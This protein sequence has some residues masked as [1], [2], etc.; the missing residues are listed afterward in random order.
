MKNGKKTAFLLAVWLTWSGIAAGAAGA[1]NEKDTTADRI[2]AVENHLRPGAY[3]KGKE[4]PEWNIYDRMKRLHVPGVSIAVIDQGKIEWAK[5]YGV[6]EVGSN[7]PVTP[8]TLFQAAS[9]SKPVTAF[10]L[11][12]Q[13][14]GGGLSLDAPVNDVLKTWKVPDNEFTAKQNVTLRHLLTHSAGMTVDGFPG[15]A[16]GE[17]V[18]TLLQVLAGEKPANTPP[19]RVDTIPGSVWRYSGG[20]FLV[21]QLML[22]DLTG[23][24]FPD[25]MQAEILDPLGMKHSTF[26]Q[27]LPRE[28]MRGA[29][30]AHDMNG[31][32]IGGKW[33]VYPELAAAGLWTTPS[34]LCRFAIAL[35]RAATG[36]DQSILST[37]L[38][39]QML[40]PGVGGWGLGI[41]V[42]EKTGPD[43]ADRFF[44]HGGG[45]KGYICMLFAYISR[46]QGA[47]I[48]T[49]S[50]GGNQLVSEI[51][52]SLAYVYK[53]E[54]M[55][56]QA[57]EVVKVPLAPYCGEYQG[58]DASQPAYRVTIKGK[59][60]HLT[61]P[62]IGDWPL[63][64][65]SDTKF[66]YIE[67]GSTVTFAK[68]PAG[69]IDKMTLWGQT[70]SKKNPGK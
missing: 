8:D 30:S 54:I 6:T 29:A 56:P 48:M 60:L 9:I 51:L 1:K 43:D 24:A 16:A 62:E 52:R 44:S 18:P 5:G 23:K 21:A 58:E 41:G 42:S 55:K 27:P 32:V 49:N 4:L 50:D 59:R 26:Q 65:L 10:A 67:G 46:G 33:H 63:S 57:V 64:P 53:W 34:D 39:Q 14:G 38:A 37:T 25:S 66:I 13:V 7:S 19:I 35:Q 70:R 11:L 69:E 28:M 68:N 20:G 12:R 61:S 31:K 17:H 40:T 36:S 45:N 47:V 15:Y 3:E 22:T 2:R